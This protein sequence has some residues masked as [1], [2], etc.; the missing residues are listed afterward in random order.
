MLIESYL[1]DRNEDLYGENLRV[2]FVARLRG[3]KRFPSVDELVRQMQLDVEEAKRMCAATIV[4]AQ[5]GQA[6]GQSS[7]RRP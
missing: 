1:I 6:E 4:A 3:E 7:S 2:A 5:A